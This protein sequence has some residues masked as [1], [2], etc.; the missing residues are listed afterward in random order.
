MVG[1][2]GALVPGDSGPSL[3]LVLLLLLLLLFASEGQ[4]TGEWRTLVRELTLDVMGGL[5]GRGAF[6]W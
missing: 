3:V 6:R 5:Y 4:A 1:R 2:D